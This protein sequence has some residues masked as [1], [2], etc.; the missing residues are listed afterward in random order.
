M[1]K[2]KPSSPACK[3]HLEKNTCLYHCSQVPANSLVYTPCKE[4]VKGTRVIF[5]QLG[6]NLNDTFGSKGIV[7][8]EEHVMDHLCLFNDVGEVYQV[9]YLGHKSWP[10]S[11]ATK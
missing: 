2:Y 8:Y 3:I 10:A 4:I 11:L 1:K 5:F 6:D 7:L 9:A